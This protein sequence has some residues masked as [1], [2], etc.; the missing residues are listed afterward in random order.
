MDAEYSAIARRLGI[1][2]VS[3][4][5]ALLLMYA[6]TLAAGF[7]S[8]ESADQPIGDP[9]FTLLEV[10]ILLMTPAMVL[11]MVAVH[12]WAPARRKALSLAAA[13]F[14]AIAAALTCAVHFA[15]LTLSRQAEFAAHETLPLL[16]SFE[17]PSLA[18]ALDILAW[19]V[20]FALSMLLASTVFSGSPLA[21]SIRAAMLLSG[22]LALAGLS[23]VVT[24]NMA[25]RN[26]GIAGYV[27]V[28]FIVVLLLGGLFYRSVTVQAE[29]TRRPGAEA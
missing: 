23:G 26:I 4:V 15:I 22:G 1:G 21:L 8:L 7:A 25:L 11:L 20:F 27:G 16:L 10:L 29:D 12:A 24:G 17:W 3:L 14:M 5:A 13:I 2:S 19:D 28:F 9:Y 18:Y 6:I